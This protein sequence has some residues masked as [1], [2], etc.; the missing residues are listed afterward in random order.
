LASI[1]ANGFW[2]KGSRKS[3]KKGRGGVEVVKYCSERCR[4]RKP[5]PVDKKIEG[6]IRALLDGE[7]GSGVEETKARDRVVKGDR[8]LV[9]TM[10]EV[11]EVVFGSR[12]DPEKVF[13]RRKNRKSRVIGGLKVG[14]NGKGVGGEWRSV[15]MESESEAGSE[16]VSGSEDGEEDGGAGLETG[17]GAKTGLGPRV[18][19]PQ[20]ESE[21]NFSVGGERGKAEKIEESAED[22]SKRLDGQRRAEERE[23]VRRAARRAV[24]FGFPRSMETVA[25]AAAGEAG[26]GT[27]SKRSKKRADHDPTP[28][29]PQRRKC[30]ALMQ[31]AVVEP[32]FAK[33]NWS[34]RWRDS[35]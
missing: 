28:T 12:F 30:E 7:H 2:G 14:G 1:G 17:L 23:M 21:V 18:R 5:G 15:D 29:E 6:V 27:A 3:A 13:G 19:P 31:G 10:E 16:E 35:Q 32:S 20:T 22:A 24:V 33:G 8:R 4:N 25:A 34:I 26:G 9:V 11:E